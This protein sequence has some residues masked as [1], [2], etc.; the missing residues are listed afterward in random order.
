MRIVCLTLA[1][2][3][4]A[5]AP[6]NAK[7]AACKRATVK[8]AIEHDGGSVDVGFGQ[9]ICRDV[10]GDGRKDALFTVLSGG[11]AGATHFGVFSRAK[12]ELYEAGYKVQV[13]RDSSRRFTLE[14]PFYKADDPN[15]CPS[16]FDYTPYTW[17]GKGFKAGRSERSKRQRF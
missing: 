4:V 6:A 1:A 9:F 15:C 7:P 12:L 8:A 2:V 16:A 3:L 10:T 5:A 17:S 14:Q 11:T 13:R